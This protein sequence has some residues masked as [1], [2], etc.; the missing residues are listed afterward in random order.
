MGR[1]E[2]KSQV[3]R[4]PD[5]HQ[6][7][8]QIR[9]DLGILRVQLRSE[10][11]SV[12]SSNRCRPRVA[13]RYPSRELPKSSCSLPFSFSRIFFRKVHIYS[14]QLLSAREPREQILRLENNA[15]KRIHG[16]LLRISRFAVDALLQDNVQNRHLGENARPVGPSADVVLGGRLHEALAT[17]HK[18]PSLNLR[19]LKGGT[20]A[21][22]IYAASLKASRLAVASRISLLAPRTILSMVDWYLSD[23]EGSRRA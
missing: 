21:T 22:R 16:L 18:A 11:Q 19:F 15:L 10:R 3:D 14:G 17:A 12:R 1:E 7:V 5:T 20:L 23:L 13:V 6:A 2:L 8:L 4:W 9:V